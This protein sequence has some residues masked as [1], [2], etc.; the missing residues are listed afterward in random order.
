VD[1]AGKVDGIMTGGAR[2][3]HKQLDSAASIGQLQSSLD[4]SISMTKHLAKKIC[5]VSQL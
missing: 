5:I 3:D 2:V 1:L 4:T